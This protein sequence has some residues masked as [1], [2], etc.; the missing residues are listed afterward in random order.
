MGT[1]AAKQLMLTAVVER[2]SRNAM[3][4]QQDQQNRDNVSKNGTPVRRARRFMEDECTVPGSRHRVHAVRHLVSS[5]TGCPGDEPFDCM[6]VALCIGSDAG[7][8]LN[9]L[10]V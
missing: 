7:L 9:R 6:H 3:R 1:D 5:A 4:R 2:Y 8:R 10:D